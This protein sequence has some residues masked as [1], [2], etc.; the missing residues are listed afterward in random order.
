MATSSAGSL[1]FVVE[2]RLV[3]ERRPFTHFPRQRR[4][5]SL[6]WVAGAEKGDRR[7]E[8]IEIRT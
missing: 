7:W 3:L 1:L 5:S 4:F 6:G 8:M 2:A